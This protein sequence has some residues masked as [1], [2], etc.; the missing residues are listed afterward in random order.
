MA[1]KQI[2]CGGFYY[3]D[4]HIRFEGTR[5]KPVLKLLVV[6]MEKLTLLNI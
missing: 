4:T 5:D 1:V 2:P 3:D 6:E